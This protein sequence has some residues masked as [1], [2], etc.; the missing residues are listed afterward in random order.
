ME[1]ILAS[2]DSIH[3]PHGL[4]SA[5]PPTH[6]LLSDFTQIWSTALSSSSAAYRLCDAPAESPEYMAFLCPTKG[7]LWNSLWFHYAGN[8]PTSEDIWKALWHLQVPSPQETRIPG[9]HFVACVLLD[10]V[11]RSRSN[12]PGSRS[13]VPRSRSNVPRSRSSVPGSRSSVPGS[14]NSVPGSRS[15]KAFAVS[16]TKT[17]YLI[18]MCVLRY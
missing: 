4:V 15:N 5:P 17:R 2:L 1:Q 12:V 3:D 9:F 10:S 8:L 18:S 14:R 16:G 7:S 6:I 13:S 11:P